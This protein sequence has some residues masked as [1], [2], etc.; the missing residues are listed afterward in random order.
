M[1]NAFGIILF[2][3]T[4]WCFDDQNIGLESRRPRFNP[5]YQ[6]I[7]CGVYIY[8]VHVCKFIIPRWVMDR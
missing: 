7:L 2:Y 8:F 4:V 3:K 1:S 6:H 5:P